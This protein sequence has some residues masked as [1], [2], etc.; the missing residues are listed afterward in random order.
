MQHRCFLSIHDDSISEA[1]VLLNLSCFPPNTFAAGDVLQLVATNDRDDVKASSLQP[2]EHGA[3]SRE[4]EEMHS[5]EQPTFSKTDER[6]HSSKTQRPNS[7]LLDATKGYYFVVRD[8]TSDLMAKLHGVQVRCRTI[9]VVDVQLS[10]QLCSGLVVN[11][12]VERFR[13]EE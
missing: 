5:L 8:M 6:L 7:E 13:L 10:L 12:D 9:W 2:M 11:A 4:K 1:D 3:G